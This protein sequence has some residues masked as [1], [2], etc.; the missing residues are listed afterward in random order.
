M[1]LKFFTFT[2]L[3]AS[4]IEEQINKFMRSVRVL[5]IKRD[6]VIDRETAYW[7]VCILYLS[8]NAPDSIVKNKT[9]YNYI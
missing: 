6:I 7:V 5:E 1:Q 8:T 2:I 9:D 4:I 3:E